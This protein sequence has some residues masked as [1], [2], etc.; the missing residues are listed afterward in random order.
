MK[1][2]QLIKIKD[3]FINLEEGSHILTFIMN[4][5]NIGLFGSKKFMTQK[6]KIESVLNKRYIK[7]PFGIRLIF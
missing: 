7:L 4:K 5:E 2:K 1:K 3:V 6:E